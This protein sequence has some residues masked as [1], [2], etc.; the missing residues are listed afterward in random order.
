MALR[1][2]CADAAREQGCPDQAVEPSKQTALLA[3]AMHGKVD[4]VKLMVE[5]KADIMATDVKG[6]TALMLAAFRKPPA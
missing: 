4:C 2:D 6:R 5:H 3:A 1:G